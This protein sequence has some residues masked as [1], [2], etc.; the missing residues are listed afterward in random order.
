[1]SAATAD[2]I[3]LTMRTKLNPAFY[4]EELRL[5]LSDEP[6]RLERML[7][8]PASVDLLTWNVFASLDRHSDRDYLAYRLHGLGGADVRAPVR[9]SLWTGRHREPLLR[10]SGAYVAAVRER[11]RQVGGTA[12]ATAAL[13]APIEV[14]VRIESADVLVLVDT[15]LDHYRSGAGGRDRVTELIDAGLEHAR[16][17]SCELAV[18][19]VYR[20]GSVGAAQ[21]S[22]RLNRLRDPAFLAA[23]LPHRKQVPEVILREL[24]WQQLLLIWQQELPYLGL[25]GQPAKSF[26]GYVR[27]LGLI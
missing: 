9:Q 23:Q 17:L 5:L 19:V 14:P 16:R 10:P 20:S 22:E 11:A 7:R 4:G 25:R 27:R 26:T 21:V 8:E 2:R 6:D 15:M 24:P 12:E 18:A 13:E 1:M 3:R